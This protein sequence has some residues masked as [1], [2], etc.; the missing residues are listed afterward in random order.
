M[1]RSDFADMVRSIGI[2]SAYQA[3]SEATAKE[4]PFICY[5][6]TG[7]HDPKADNTNYVCVRVMAIELYTDE[8]DFGLESQIEEALRDAGMV[9]SVEPDYLDD[10]KMYVTVYTMEVIFDGEQD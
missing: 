8:K 4:P 2:P 5:F 6:E 3:F 9:Y 7:D 10:Q 1:T